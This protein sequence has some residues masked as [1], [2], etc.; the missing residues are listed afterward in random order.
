M[1][2]KVMAIALAAATVS[3]MMGAS[4]VSAAT[5]VANNDLAYKGDLEIMH[6]STSEE[7]EGNGG[8]DGSVPYWQHGTMLIRIST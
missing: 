7:S 5:D 8:S 2:K 4:M 3:S 1:K 6:Y